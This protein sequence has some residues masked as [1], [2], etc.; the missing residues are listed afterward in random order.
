VQGVLS[1]PKKAYPRNGLLWLESAA[2]WLRDEQS[3]VAAQV[4]TEGFAKLANDG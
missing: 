3:V 2:T 4:L 1:E